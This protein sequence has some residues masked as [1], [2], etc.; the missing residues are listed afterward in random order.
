[1]TS[2]QEASL[3][4]KE[5]AGGMENLIMSSA[6]A[7][8]VLGRL[9]RNQKISF[10]DVESSLVQVRDEQTS[11][12]TED[13]ESSDA[14][15]ITE[16]NAVVKNLPGSAETAKVLE[17]KGICT[18][19]ENEQCDKVKVSQ[20]NITQEEKAQETTGGNTKGII[21][22]SK[23]K[24]ALLDTC[25]YRHIAI[26]FLYDGSLYN[27]FAENVGST[28][29]NSVEKQVFAALTKT[30]LVRKDEVLEDIV[31]NGVK[32][33]DCKLSANRGRRHAQCQYSR[34]GRTDRGVSA[35]GQ[36]IG[37]RVR[38]K[39]PP[40]DAK[41]GAIAESDLPRNSFQTL[42]VYMP[43]KKGN[44]KG[45]K[46][47]K[48]R[49][50]AVREETAADT[51]QE[52]KQDEELQI[53]DMQELDYCK[54]LNGVLPETI[55]C[56]GWTP[57]SDEYSA[58]FS[59]RDRTYRYFF[60]RRNLNL[61]A[62]EEG[63]NRMVGTHD[64][65]NLCKM[66]TEAVSNFIRVIKYAKVVVQ[67]SPSSSSEPQE[68]PGNSEREICYFEICGQAFLWHMIRC[69]VSVCFMIGKDLEDPSVVTEL[70]DVKKHPGKPA[71]PMA[72]DLPLVLHQCSFQNVTF[73]HSSLNLWE[74]HNTLEHQWEQAALAAERLRNAL[75]SLQKE[76]YI[77]QAEFGS[78]VCN[79]LIPSVIGGG[80]R[81]RN[82][83]VVDSLI[84]EAAAGATDEKLSQ[85]L[86]QVRQARVKTSSCNTDNE[87]TI[88]KETD[89]NS[90]AKEERKANAA[91]VLSWGEAVAILRELGH[92]RLISPASK[93]STF[94][95]KLIDRNKGTTYEEKI[96]AMKGKRKE[97]F[98]A[99]IRKQQPHEADQEFYDKKVKE[100]GSG[101]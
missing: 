84:K 14:E 3:S 43:Q 61:Q 44:G 77:Q 30:C 100:G 47:P 91:S 26:R 15:C 29:D 55:R 21:G 66:D 35:F 31:L 5:K 96:S 92:Y 98:E 38:S 82:N 17:G 2:K 39:I 87:D 85:V 48:K 11:I 70:L 18:K 79:D 81:S 52:E 62:M 37:L 57:V 49:K 80:R 32:N 9:I 40:L 68:D 36:V 99:N 72:S 41:N 8:R 34:S 6:E 63:L 25:R 78:F 60:V 53:V 67:P 42:S 58:R 73:G 56:L 28:T 33:G 71:Y 86:K 51:K 23:K 93:E 27:G 59:A 69:I 1:M 75:D 95:I 16:E 46:A 88:A 54:I 22:R 74:V 65:R 45:S 89:A 64:F 19:A 101:I 13:V 50:R 83:G 97:R 4:D 7:V 90:L 94:H 24:N 12:E 76:A 10:G 20:L